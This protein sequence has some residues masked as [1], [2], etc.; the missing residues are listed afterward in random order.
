MR[1]RGAHKR[2]ARGRDGAY[3]AACWTFPPRVHLITRAGCRRLHPRYLL[4]R[5][6]DADTPLF[7][8]EFTFFCTTCYLGVGGVANTQRIAPACPPKVGSA[9]RP[10]RHVGAC[11]R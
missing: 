6:D 7:I 8:Q 3:I 2:I 9:L 5:V 1:G 11:W 10:V 4:M